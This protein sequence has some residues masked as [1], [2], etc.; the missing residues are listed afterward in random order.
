MTV[1]DTKPDIKKQRWWLVYLS[2]LLA[3]LL[4]LADAYSLTQLHRWTA[5]LGIALVYSA[6]C[7]FAGRGRLVGYIAAAIIWLAVVTTLFV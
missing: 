4:L 7:L 6:V 5:R 1:D 2:L 3:G